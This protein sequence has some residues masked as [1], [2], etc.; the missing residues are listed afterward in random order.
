MSRRCICKQPLPITELSPLC[1]AEWDGIN[2]VNV[3]STGIRDRKEISCVIKS[4]I[5]VARATMSHSSP[6]PPAFKKVIKVCVKLIHACFL[7]T[8]PRR[9]ATRYPYI[10][11]GFARK[12]N[13]EEEIIDCLSKRVPL[14]PTP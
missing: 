10:Q 13:L 3:R 7:A 14:L 12:P 2:H 6:S 8:V 4:M 1:S 5:M 9:N 11:Y